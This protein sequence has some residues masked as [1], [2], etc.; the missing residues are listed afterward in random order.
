MALSRRLML[1]LALATSLV[2][3]PALAQKATEIDL[4]FPVP[5]DGKLAKDMT[6]LIQEFNTKHPSIK[7]T[8]VYTGSYDE[9]LVKTRAAIKAGKAP[10]AVIMSANF[11]LDMQIE[12]ELTNLDGLIKADNST[13][14]Q[15]LA[16]FFPALH[17][18]AVINRSVYAVP[19]HNSTPLLYINA[20]HMKEAGLDPDK[21]PQTWAELADM[22]QKLTK[23]DGDKVTRWVSIF[24]Q[25]MTISAGSCRPSPCPMVDATITR[26]SAARSI[27]IHPPCWGLSPSGTTLSRNTRCIRLASRLALP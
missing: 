3:A 25:A 7:A 16:Q 21:M 10:A 2:S 15:F 19:F 6:T 27:T 13:N 22:A 1:S 23:R 14:E 17:G 26:N 5:V 4:F 20:D 24:P 12:N 8:A 18:N 11:V 9:T